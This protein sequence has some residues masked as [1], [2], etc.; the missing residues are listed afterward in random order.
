MR[1]ILGCLLALT[2][3]LGAAPAPQKK[4][5]LIVNGSFEEGP[6]VGRYQAFNPG[7]T[8]IKGWTVTRGQIDIVDSYWPGAQG[9]RSIDLHGSPGFG[10]IQQTIATKPGRSYTVTFSLAGNPDG[11]VPKK[12]I[13]VSAGKQKTEFTFDATGKTLKDMGWVRKTWRF[14]ATEKETVVEFFTLMQ[15]DD[16]CG[17]VIDDV[18]VIEDN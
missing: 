17:P 11:S 10:G 2:P 13:G 14:T 1:A 3:F 12:E 6:Q 8:E 7:S 16:A 18:S 9:N 15:V 4:P 5:N